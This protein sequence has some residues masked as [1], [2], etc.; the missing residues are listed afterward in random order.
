MATCSFIKE[1]KQ[2]AGAMKGVMR[3]VSRNQKTLG[4]KRT[5]TVAKNLWRD[6][7]PA[8][9][10]YRIEVREMKY[11]FRRFSAAFSALETPVNAAISSFN[12]RC[13][14]VQYQH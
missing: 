5:E 1:A 4:I 10:F 2:T 6:N 11:Y 8:R 3:Y 12:H 14:L 13:G 7:S 9:G